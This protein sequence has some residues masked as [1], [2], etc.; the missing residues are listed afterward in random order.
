MSRPEFPEGKRAAVAKAV[1]P[2]ATAAAH[3]V[4]VGFS[5][6]RTKARRRLHFDRIYDKIAAGIPSS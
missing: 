2:E 5:R 4:V 3:S 6:R 1:M